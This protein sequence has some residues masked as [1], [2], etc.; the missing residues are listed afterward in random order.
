MLFRALAPLLPS[1]ERVQ[2]H[3]L[4]TA[5]VR[6]A[7]NPVLYTQ[8]GI[9]DTVAGRAESVMLYLALLERRLAREPQAGALRRLVNEA[10]VHDMD[11]S[12]REMG[13]GDTGVGKRVKALASKLLGRLRAY[14]AAFGDDAALGEALRRNLYMDAAVEDAQTARLIAMLRAEDAALAALSLSALR[15]GK[16]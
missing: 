1:S 4:Y 15:E 9:P 3:E 13:I 5:L 2:A 11:R 8:C 7:R 10:F 6:R 16:L 12:L 14:N